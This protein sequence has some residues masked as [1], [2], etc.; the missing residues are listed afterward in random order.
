MEMSQILPLAGSVKVGVKQCRVD[1]LQSNFIIF[2][3]A[4]L[5]LLGFEQKSRQWREAK[6]DVR[7]CAQRLPDS[8]M[9]RIPVNKK[10]MEVKEEVQSSSTKAIDAY[11]SK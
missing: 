3:D 1:F 9:K 2:L 10:F 8:N 5:R 11:V 7:N 4:F 6:N